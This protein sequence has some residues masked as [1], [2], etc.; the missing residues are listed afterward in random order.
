MKQ[1][2]PLFFICFV[3]F[4]DWDQVDQSTLSNIN[5]NISNIRQSVESLNS[6][7]SSFNVNL[8]NIKNSNLDILSEL[9][10]ISLGY[11]T[12]AETGHND[13]GLYRDF[14][15]TVSHFGDY[16]FQMR[17]ETQ[18]FLDYIKSFSTNNYTNTISSAQ[19]AN[20]FMSNGQYFNY[21][22]KMLIKLNNDG[23]N[24]TDSW[25]SV[26]VYNGTPRSVKGLKASIQN[27]IEEIKQVPENLPNQVADPNVLFSLNLNTIADLFVK[28]NLWNVNPVH[29]WIIPVKLVPVEGDYLYPIYS[30]WNSEAFYP[31]TFHLCIKGLICLFAFY[32]CYN[33][34]VSTWNA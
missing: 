7:N 31:K 18:D 24:E 17:D 22:E 8:A 4:A 27:R 15:N 14:Y 21:S 3:C 12:S 25:F 20:P 6:S 30:W 23:I 11:H 19:T 2:I 33:Y 32:Y 9:Q 34:V 16:H 29:N 1:I 5:T 28:L 13:L 10:E 26:D